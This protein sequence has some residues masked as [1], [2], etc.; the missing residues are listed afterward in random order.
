MN[1]MIITTKSAIFV[2][3]LEGETLTDKDF[4]GMIC[5]AYQQARAAWMGKGKADEFTASNG[6]Q[7][8]I[9]ER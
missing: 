6:V 3:S 9:V 1:T 8:Q 2:F 4:M 5:E 7:V